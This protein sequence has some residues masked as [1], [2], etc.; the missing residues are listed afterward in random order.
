MVINFRNRKFSRVPVVKITVVKSYHRF[1]ANSD[2]VRRVKIQIAPRN[3][4]DYSGHSRMD[5]DM[6]C[7][8]PGTGEKQ[9]D[10]LHLPVKR[11]RV[12]GEKYLNKGKVC[13]SFTPQVVYHS[14]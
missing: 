3:F 13:I 9:G 1:P 7:T 14:I 11:D 5:A 12:E 10:L 2:K 8:E 4:T 6:G